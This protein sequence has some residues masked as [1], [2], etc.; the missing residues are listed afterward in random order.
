MK[1]FFFSSIEIS[2]FSPSISLQDYFSLEISLQD[3]FFHLKSPIPP[4]PP[5]KSQMFSPWMLYYF[6]GRKAL[7]RHIR[8]GV[9]LPEIVRDDNY[10]FN[11]QVSF[12]GI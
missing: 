10:D 4:P 7:L 11:F 2:V 9:E 5:L 8:G 6:Q 12:T 3:I 1:N